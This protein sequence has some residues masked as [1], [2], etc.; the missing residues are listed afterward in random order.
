M[1]N[2]LITGGAGFIGSNLAN[3][4][5]KKSKITIID[6]LSM[7]RISNIDMNEN[8][9][10]IQ[11]S[12]CDYL[13]MKELLSSQKFDYIFHLAA[14]ASVADSVENPLKTYK[15][16]FDA[17]VHL[18]EMVKEY[19]SGLKRLVFSSSASVYGDEKTI[20]KTEESPIQPMTPYA[21]DKFASERYILN[22][23][24][25][26]NVP[27]TATRFFNVFGMNQ[28]PKSPYSGVISILMDKYQALIKG[29]D[30]KFTL[31]GNGNQSRDFIFI[32]D[33]IQGLELI[34]TSNNAL[35][36][37]FNFGLGKMT[38]LNE[39]IEILNQVFEVELPI[40]YLP[41]RTG[42][43]EKSLANNQKLVSIGFE[44]KYSLKEGLTQYIS[45][46]N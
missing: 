36:E 43:I 15:V 14:I 23:Y 28:N 1:E 38:T 17:T 25:L 12:I 2:I 37:V 21:I 26:Y 33:V 41:A 46:L 27:T 11:T 35:G 39:L 10:F 5:S 20:P 45:S 3:H 4:L 7:G 6:D 31:F 40:E 8:I 22:A 19:Q 18:L 42:D 44:P 9:T 34:A 13:K 16:N 29:E 30:V 32:N 24:K